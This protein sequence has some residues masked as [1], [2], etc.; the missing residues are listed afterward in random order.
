[1]KLTIRD[2]VNNILIVKDNKLLGVVQEID[3]HT[4]EYKRIVGVNPR[5]TEERIQSSPF[6][7]IAF[8]KWMVETGTAD[9]IIVGPVETVVEFAEKYK[10]GEV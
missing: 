9:F 7:G 3:L 4:L 6:L 5:P 2:N 1:M 10:R 8:E